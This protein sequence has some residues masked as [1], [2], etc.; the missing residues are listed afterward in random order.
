MHSRQLMY[1]HIVSDIQNCNK[2][3]RDEKLNKSL[4]NFLYS[5]LQEDH[6]G[7]AKKSL[8]VLTELYR[9]NVWTDQR[10]VPE[11]FRP[12][13]LHACNTPQTSLAVKQCRGGCQ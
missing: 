4:Q 1:S 13:F 3:H 5:Q 11:L 12:P 2:R 7:C 6:E 10:T 9:R 8:A